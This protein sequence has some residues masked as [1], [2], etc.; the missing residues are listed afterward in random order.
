MFVD[1]KPCIVFVA[2]LWNITAAFICGIVG[3]EKD[4]H[5]LAPLSRE[6]KAVRIKCMS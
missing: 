6:P 5:S 2:S 3:L 1:T 4:I